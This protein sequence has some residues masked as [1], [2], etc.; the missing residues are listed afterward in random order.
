LPEMFTLH[1]PSPVAIGVLLVGAT[2]P[3]TVSPSTPWNCIGHAA[4][5]SE[6]LPLIV[7]C[8]GR[9]VGYNTPSRKP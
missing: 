3:V 9:Y 5:V 1:N 7:T 6:L 2:L 4:A 8:C